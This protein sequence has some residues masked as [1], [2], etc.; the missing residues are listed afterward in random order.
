[1]ANLDGVFVPAEP[2]AL[3]GELRKSN[4]RRILFDPA[5]KLVQSDGIRHAAALRGRGYLV[6]TIC[7][8]VLALRPAS[9]VTPRTMM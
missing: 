8:N 2:P 5:S 9:S 4:R 7:L 1:V 6:T 3:F